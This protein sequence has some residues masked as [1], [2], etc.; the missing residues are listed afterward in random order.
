MCRQCGQ[1]VP[2]GR[3][4][5]CGEACID[6]WKIRTDPGFIRE[7]LIQR[8]HGICAACRLDTIALKRFVREQPYRFRV[9][10]EAGMKVGSTRTFWEAD[11][12]RPVQEGGGLCGLDGLQTLCCW[13]HR[14][15]TA[16]Q[17]RRVADQKRLE[18]QTG[19]A[20]LL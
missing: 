10:W 14:L 15:K 13:C 3:R 17:A 7:K 11:H 12:V 18:G 16:E 1:E 6:A 19:Q 4:T 8:D 9:A 20:R 5:F 2:R